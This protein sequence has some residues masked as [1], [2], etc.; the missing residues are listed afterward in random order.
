MTSEQSGLPALRI[1]ARDARMHPLI[2]G[3]LQRLL[4]GT[5][6]QTTEQLTFGDY[7][8]DG[9]FDDRKIT[10]GIE[11]SSVNDV[12]GKINSNRLDYQLTG[13]LNTYDVSILMITGN[14]LPDKNGYVVVYGAPRNTKYERFANALFSAQMHGV[15][16]D[17]AP[18]GEANAA[19]RIAHHYK[20]WQ[21]AKHDSFRGLKAKDEKVFLPTGEGIDHQVQAVMAWPG[22]GEK[23][24]RDALRTFG[25]IRALTQMP[26]TELR[27]IPGWGV[28][29]SANIFD[30]L[31]EVP[32]WVESSDE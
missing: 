18:P 24:A 29:T 8:F 17:N 23:M 7:V 16:V 30:F 31:G 1:D 28:T 12:I 3:T 2:A 6:I 20:Y 11:L 19:L 26:K 14:Y 25:S 15:V 10:I 13:M 21:K 27:K 9:V 22:I 4:P 5:T 32:S